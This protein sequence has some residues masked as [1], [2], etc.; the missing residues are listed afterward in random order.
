MFGLRE[1][2]RSEGE[3]Q[4]VSEVRR[5]GSGM[6]AFGLT[7]YELVAA[8]SLGEGVVAGEGEHRQQPGG[9]TLG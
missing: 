9:R 1:R 3:G 2:G 7:D 5:G 8:E 6:G 4:G